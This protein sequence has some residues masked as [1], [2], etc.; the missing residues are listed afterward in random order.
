MGNYVLY[1]SLLW[2]LG[3][4]PRALSQPML[5]RFSPRSGPTEGGTNIS[6]WGSGFVEITRCN[7]ANLPAASIPSLTAIVHNSTFMTCVLPE[8][9]TAF[10]FPENSTHNIIQFRV[11]TSPSQQSS[12]EDFLV[13]NLTTILV[14]GLNFTSGFILSSDNLVQFNGTNFVNTSELYCF[15]GNLREPATFISDQAVSCSLPSYPT[16]SIQYPQLSLNGDQSGFIPLHDNSNAFVFYSTAPILEKAEFS[17]S[18]AQLILMFDREVELGGENSTRT[19]QSFECSEIFDTDTSN[20]LGGTAKCYWQTS[21][22][23]VIIIQLHVNS[24]IIPND[25]VT[26]NG[27]SIRTRGVQYSMLSASTVVIPAPEGPIPVAVLEAPGAIPACGMLQ[28]VARNSLYG[29]GRPLVY[30]WAVFTGN[31]ILNN[32]IESQDESFVEIPIESLADAGPY[33]FTVTVSN[34][35]GLQDTTTISYLH[36]S[37]SDIVLVTIYGNH[38][39]GYPVDSDN[40]VIEA[41]AEIMSCSTVSGSTLQYLW[42]ITDSSNGSAITLAPTYISISELWIPPMTLQI[43]TT[44]DVQLSVQYMGQSSTAGTATVKVTGLHPELTAALQTGYRS[45]VRVTEQI[46]LDTSPSRGLLPDETYEYCWACDLCGLPD[47]SFSS[48][49]SLTLPVNA[50][51]LGSY[52]FTVTITHSGIGI[53]SKASTMLEV[54]EAETVAGVITPSVKLALPTKWNA[55]S[56]NDKS[57]V[58]ASVSVPTA[59]TVQWSTTEV[60]SLGGCLNSYISYAIQLAIAILC[61]YK[62]IMGY[63]RLHVG[64]VFYS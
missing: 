62:Y 35:L 24:M 47:N 64:D 54:I 60:K 22:Q 23:R 45:S 53:S 58:T 43:G 14:T 1:F 27:A 48:D 5:I 18:A 49:S 34:F 21:Q 8:I 30:E 44:Y 36:K 42:T 41:T 63:M 11:V 40:I 32:L 16:P 57:V 13:F 7:F 3:V 10:Q 12:E 50:L 55:L 2:L 19:T 59:A 33:N 37:S 52:Q 28:L 20:L 56:A 51:P 38:N 4:V 31:E 39:R 29:G 25:A 15:V 9:T 26:L 61:G 6:V 46:H 17:S